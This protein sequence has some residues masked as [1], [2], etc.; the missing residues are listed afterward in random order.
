DPLPAWAK[1]NPNIWFVIP[2]QKPVA[3]PEA[4]DPTLA[5]GI[6]AKTP[7]VKKDDEP[8]LPADMVLHRLIQAF[9]LDA[10]ELTTNPLG[11]FAKRLE[12]SLPSG[13]ASDAGTDTYRIKSVIERV[14]TAKRREQETDQ[15]DVKP[16]ASALEQV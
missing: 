6:Q 10:P 2:A 11:F 15:A 16:S 5:G 1:E 4:S 13:D 12:R 9:D 8:V 14:R 3:K 7:G